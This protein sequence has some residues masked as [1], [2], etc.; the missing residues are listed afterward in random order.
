MQINKR[1]V[2][3]FFTIAALAILAIILTPIIQQQFA[4]PEDRIIKAYEEMTNDISSSSISKVGTVGIRLYDGSEVLKSNSNDAIYIKHYN[5]D[6][7]L[8]ALKLMS[9][10]D[11]AGLYDKFSSARKQYGASYDSAIKSGEVPSEFSKL[12]IDDTFKGA[13]GIP[14]GANSYAYYA[15]YSKKLS[16]IEATYNVCSAF[17]SEYGDWGKGEDEDGFP[18][19]DAT[20]LNSKQ[21]RLSDNGNS[22]VI[23][24]EPR[25]LSY[26]DGRNNIGR[27]VRGML[28]M[29]ERIREE[30]EDD[31]LE[32]AN[33]SSSAKK[34]NSTHT[35]SW[36]D[37]EMKVKHSSEY[38]YGT[39]S[40]GKTEYT[41]EITIYKK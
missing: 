18:T 21:L 10:T 41:S 11:K 17:Y 13:I 5:E 31:W 19:S 28:E 40:R 34:A 14:I 1:N 2:V 4:S 22:L 12:E 3:V 30:F 16:D 24:I 37:F 20:T 39:S 6:L 23:T 8:I 15:V 27:C 29:P 38:Q 7:P 32:Y 33:G 36:N 9:L 25:N 35:Y 26:P